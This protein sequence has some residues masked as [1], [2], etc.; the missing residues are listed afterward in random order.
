MKIGKYPVKHTY[1]IPRLISDVF[2][3]GLAVFIC[4]VEYMFLTVYEDT[5]VRY[6]GEEQ[7]QALSQADS[8]IGWKHW[9]TLI[10]PVLVLAVFAVYI[11]LVLKSHRFSS[12]NITKRN[13]QKVYDMYALC[14]SLCKIPALMLISEMMMITQ[15]KLLMSEESWFTIQLVL[16]LF[17]IVLLISFF[18]RMILRFTAPVESTADSGAIK[19]KAV[20]KSEEPEITSDEN[21]TDSNSERS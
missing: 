6:I 20:V 16:D 7:L 18:R 13:A 10:F 12:L 1:K 14:A 15:N 9:T 11:F 17:I 3:V 19:V 8:S 21:N 2:S 4:S 5:L